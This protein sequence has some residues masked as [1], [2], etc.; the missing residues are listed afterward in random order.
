MEQR[1]EETQQSREGILSA[2]RAYRR[3]PRYKNIVHLWEFLLELLAKESCSSF[4]S[5]VRKERGEFILKNP[6][7]VSRRWGMMKGRQGMNYGKLSRALRYYYQQEIIQKVPGK[8]L[9]YKFGKLPYKYKLGMREPLDCRK[10]V[11][12]NFDEREVTRANACRPQKV[13]PVPANCSAA[14]PTYTPPG[15]LLS[16]KPMPGRSMLWYPSNAFPRRRMDATKRGIIYGSVHLMR[17]V[18]VRV[19][20][21]LPKTLPVSVIHH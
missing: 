14:T 6:E 18:Y 5:W 17:P 9:V 11:V 7:E 12:D 13:L 20:R 21:F 3:Q 15:C 8:R 10:K 4:I 2:K 1:P 19:N 16:P